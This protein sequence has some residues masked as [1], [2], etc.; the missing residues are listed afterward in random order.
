MGKMDAVCVSGCVEICEVLD[1]IGKN[2]ILKRNFASKYEKWRIFR[3]V[4]Y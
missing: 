4:V 1:D 3:G 2:K